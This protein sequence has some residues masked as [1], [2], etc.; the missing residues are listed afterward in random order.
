MDGVKEI[1]R[2]AAKAWMEA[3]TCQK[4][5]SKHLLGP[6]FNKFP[7]ISHTLGA[8]GLV[9]EFA[10]TIV[11]DLNAPFS[12]RD[13]QQI[14]QCR[15]LRDL[16]C[17]IDE[18]FLDES[19]RGYAWGVEYTDDEFRKSL[20]RAN[21]LLPPGIAWIHPFVQPQPMRYATTP[22]RLAIY[23]ANMAKLKVAVARHSRHKEVKPGVATS[24]DDDA[25]YLG[26]KV[27]GAPLVEK[28]LPEPV[29]KGKH[30]KEHHA[31]WFREVTTQQ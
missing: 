24:N 19:D 16:V 20:N 29:Q 15:R 25:L 31:S 30:S 22:E 4:F 12:S 10:R 3:R 21:F 23:S 13:S 8:N 6:P 5:V 27:T 26:S 14:S 9:L 18:D 1:L 7:I 17:V 11:L 28:K 2:A